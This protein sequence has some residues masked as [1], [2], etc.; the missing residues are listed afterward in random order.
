M[1][2]KKQKLSRGDIFRA[3]G[4]WWHL[5]TAWDDGV[6]VLA[7][8]LTDPY[9]P[10]RRSMGPPQVLKLHAGTVDEVIHQGGQEGT[11]TDPMKGSGR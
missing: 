1:A 8:P 11:D 7:T 4:G 3:H 9:W 5:C 6:T 2:K 10:E